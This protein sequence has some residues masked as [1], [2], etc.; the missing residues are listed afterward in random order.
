MT[1]SQTYVRDRK[2]ILKAG[3][4]G[5]VVAASFYLSGGALAQGCNLPGKPL[6]WTLEVLRPAVLVAGWQMVGPYLCEGSRFLQVLLQIG[7]CVRPLF[8]IVGG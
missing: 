6:W 8:G 2:R 7:A 1:G 4:A 3:A 5:F